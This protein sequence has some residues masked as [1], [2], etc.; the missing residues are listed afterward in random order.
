[1]KD[2]KNL[3]YSPLKRRLKLIGVRCFEGLMFLLAMGLLFVTIFIIPE[4]AKAETLLRLDIVHISAPSITEIGYGLNAAFADL[5]YRDNGLTVYGGLGYHS[6]SS[7]CP[8]V[9]FND[10]LLARF[11]LSYEFRL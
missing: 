4:Q 11:G 5:V 2:Y 1:M 7:D 9:C 10:D 8:E 6:E 3:K